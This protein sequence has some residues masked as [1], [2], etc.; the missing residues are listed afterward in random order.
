MGSSAC[1]P[2]TRRVRF[3]SRQAFCPLAFAACPF[4]TRRDRVGRDGPCNK[5]QGV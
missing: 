4:L 5:E 3:V 1:L 2:C